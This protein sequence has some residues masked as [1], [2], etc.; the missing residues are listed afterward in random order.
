MKKLII[1][2]AI[3]AFLFFAP[4][5]SEDFVE[6]TNPNQITT[7]TFWKTSNDAL[8]GVN[9]VYSAL[10]YD[11]L[12]LRL[13][14][15]IMDIRADDT[16]NTSPWWTQETM[17][18]LASPGNPTYIAPWEHNYAGIFWA[19][20]VLTFVPNIEMNADLKARIIAEARFL[21]GLYYYHLL[22]VYRDV[23]LVTSLPE[24]PE[25]FYPS[26]APREQVWE[27]VIE[28]FK[29]AMAVLPTKQQYP[30][31]EMGRATKGAAAGY[32]AKSYVITKQWNLAEPVLKS[33]INQEYGTYAL[34]ANYRDNFTAR[35]E[36]NS[37]SLFEVQ[38]S[39]A[40]GGTELGW[41]GN[42]SSAW[43]KTSGKAR[44]YAPLGFGW[45]DVTP[46]DWIF[47]LFQEE[48]T[49]TG[50]LD[51]R[52]YASMFFDYPGSMVYGRPFA[53]ANLPNHVHVRKYLND[54][55]AA[56]EN[57]WRSEIN[58]RILRYADILLLYAETLNE[59]GR[60]AEAYPFIQQVRS[61]AN[62]PDLQSVK[63]NMSK[64]DMFE[65]ITRE[66]ALEFCFEAIRYVDILRWGWLEDPNRIEMLKSRDAEYERF[67]PGR[68]FMAIPPNEVDIN[69]NLDQD[70]GWTN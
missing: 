8:A 33:I 19:N 20:Q 41:A 61:R 55:T 16:R 4:G 29:A 26:K 23:P 65:W 42:P 67:V 10:Y 38:F 25:D 7:G 32:L 40:V 50:D 5:C 57:E 12:Y 21:R 37:E 9:S 66:R 63:P 39:R 58:E 64:A 18:Y 53:Q 3:S 47:N 69:K 30:A 56:N 24:G 2:A 49:T 60:T 52:L 36:N 48:K 45:G 51:P 15:W 17:N 22:N 11:G 46:T 70:P 6:L 31:S 62:L 14:P 27:H 59:L 68:H 34:V 44:T 43:S 35:N 54:D 1:S 13:Y 28:D